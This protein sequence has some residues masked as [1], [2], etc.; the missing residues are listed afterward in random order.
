MRPLTVSLDEKARKKKTKF[1]Y[2]STTALRSV[3][4][5]RMNFSP[6]EYPIVKSAVV[7]ELRQRGSNVLRTRRRTLSGERN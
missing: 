6:Q 4:P 1:V 2:R 7:R 3:E 5:R